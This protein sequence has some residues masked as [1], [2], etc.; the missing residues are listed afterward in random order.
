MT[1]DII[2]LS[3]TLLGLTDVIDQIEEPTNNTAKETSDK[4]EDL[5][6]FTNF[7]V[8]EITKNYLPLSHT[9]NIYSNEN[10]QIPFINFSKT[11]IAIKSIKN[12]SYQPVT[13][14]LYP[15]FVKVGFPNQQYQI[16][17]NYIPN[18]IETIEQKLDLPFGLGYETVSYGVASEYALSRLLYDEADMWEGKFKNSL[19][20]IKSK[21]GER[22]FYSRRLS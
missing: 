6:L 7:V 22:R 12:Q 10:C 14:N 15:S 11:P 20:N 17:Y 9:E 3:A 16:T 18:K 5:I 8:R 1:K 2:K 13:F 21:H 19:E 4:I